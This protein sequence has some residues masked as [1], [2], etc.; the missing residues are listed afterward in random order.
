MSNRVQ[1]LRA[2]ASAKRATVL[3]IDDDP[4]VQLMLEDIIAG[5]GADFVIAGS[6]REA[7]DVL[8][9][10]HVDLVL[11]DRRLPDSDGLLLL[12]AI[13]SRS[14]C[15]VIILSTMDKSRDKLLGIGLGATEYVTKPF[16]PLELSSRIRRLLTARSETTGPVGHDVCL[17]AGMTFDPRSRRLDTERHHIILAPAET[18]LLHALLLNEGQVQTRDELTQ[19]TCGREWSPGDRTIDVLINR[20]RGRLRSFPVEIVTVHRAGYLLVSNAEVASKT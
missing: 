20:L 6:A 15:P 18:R 12:Q 14:D 8:A 4:I 19:F 17:V 16:N 13:K 3:C 11:L 10:T 7:E 5:A 9:D 2:S 1:R